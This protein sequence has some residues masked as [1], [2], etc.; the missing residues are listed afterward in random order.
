MHQAFRGLFVG[1]D[2]LNEGRIE[3]VTQQ[4]VN[5]K[6]QAQ[7]DVSKDGKKSK[8]SFI[9]RLSYISLCSSAQRHVFGS[10]RN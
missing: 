5:I 2:H 7:M 8:A 4:S 6:Q 9:I 10:D 1:R 3:I